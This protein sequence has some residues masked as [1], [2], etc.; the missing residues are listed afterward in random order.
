MSD[1]MVRDNHLGGFV[2]GGDIR[3]YY[4]EMWD[5]II[6]DFNIKTLIDIGCGQGHELRYF[7][8]KGLECLGIDGSEKVLDHAVF[9]PIIIH[10]YTT[11]A[12]IPDKI[13]DLAWSC[14]FVEHVEAQ[15]VDNFIQ[16]FLKA[17]VVAM[18]HATPK[19]GGYHHVNEQEDKYWID[20]MEKAGFFYA[21]EET[22]LYRSLAHDYF[23]KSGLL[24]LNTN[25]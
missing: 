17:R 13:Y 11:G 12:Y 14:E 3:C 21:V 16:T 19:Q 6:S 22:Q 5:K 24:F 8:D 10:D 7:E 25:V 1:R 20:I 2:E 18:S 4:P 23:K 9:V 15:F